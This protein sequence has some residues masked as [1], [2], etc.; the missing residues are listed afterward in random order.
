[1]LV[2]D[3]DHQRVTEAKVGFHGGILDLGGIMHGN[4]RLHIGLK[5]QSW[6]E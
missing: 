6:H 2:E 1:M 4:D 5:A 3:P